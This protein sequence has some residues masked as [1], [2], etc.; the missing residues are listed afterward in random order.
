MTP[1]DGLKPEAHREVERK[2]LVKNLPE[3]LESFKS[4]SIIQGY[5]SITEDGTETRIRQKGD[6][7]FRTIKGGTGINR[8]EDETEIS[9]EEFDHD[10][11]LV[12]DR[13]IEKTRYEIPLENGNIAELDVY[14][15]KL[16]GLIVVEVEFADESSANGFVPPDWFGTEVTTDAGYK[17][18]S[19]AVNGL[20]EGISESVP[21]YDLEQGVSVLVEKVRE[22]MEETD[23][24]II[25]LVAGGSA[26]G[27][28]SAVADKVHKAFGDDSI[29]LSLDD[30]YRGRQFMSSMS[31][32]GVDYNYDQP[33]VINLDLFGV[34]LEAL[35][36]GETIEKPVYNFSIGEADKTEIVKPRKVIVVEGL[37]AL[38]EKLVHIG[39]VKAFVEVG[40][41]GRL[42]RRILRDIESRGQNPD[43]ILDYFAK[44][45]EPMHGEYIEGTKE[46]ADLIIHN[47][48]NPQVEAR[49]IKEVQIK[50]P[51]TIKP[52]VLRKLRA[53]RIGN[54]TQIDTYY[55]PIG[56]NLSD[57][58]ESL[59]VRE[60]DG[61]NT[62]SYKG[63]KQ[64]GNFRIRPK[65][66]FEIDPK[67]T[68]A[69]IEMYGGSTQVIK[70]ERTLFQ[71]NGVTFSLDKVNKVVDGEDV[72]LRNFVEIR[73][74][75]TQSSDNLEQVI[76]L[77]GFNLIDGDK[78]AYSEM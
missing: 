14:A 64:T 47:E 45:V 54:S 56:R 78:R 40:T 4:K 12:E 69:F 20:P 75:D 28:T 17:N 24:P 37:F 1:E 30:Y 31:E 72:D 60:E 76:K 2:F 25:V 35:K 7:Y 67:T 39:D 65:I 77:L 21:E 41:H 27:K 51:G 48:Y 5:V 46:E 42:I 16:Q 57:T 29:I 61:R 22:K 32:E 18:A 58:G 50:F 43:D 26:S 23:E 9:K 62:V 15:G 71:L 10:W 70:K 33:E 52:E 53:E 11:T 49:G 6:K 34:H 74:V 63:P 59:R 36:R 38:N 73:S 68:K 66:D 44:V 3:D 55:N 19:L 13:I 8:S